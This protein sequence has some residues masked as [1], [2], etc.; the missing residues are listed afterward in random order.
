MNGALPKGRFLSY[1][2]RRELA[3]DP[4]PRSRPVPRRQLPVSGRLRVLHRRYPH[5]GALPCPTTGRIPRS[6]PRGA[7]RRRPHPVVLALVLVTGSVWLLAAQVAVFALGAFA[8]PR[9]PRTPGSSACSSRPR[10][11]P[12]GAARGRRAAAL[13]PGRRLR[14]RRRRAR[15]LRR[16]ASPRSASP[17]PRSRWPPRSSTRPS[18]SAWAASCTWLD[19][20]PAPPFD[21]CRH[22]EGSHPHEPRRTS[23]SPPT[24]PRRTSTTP[25]GSSSSKSTRTPPPTTAATSRAP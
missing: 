19:P 6:T 12:P 3:A 10:L 18:A 17:P 4:T 2:R 1:P 11:G 16:S 25:K 5:S 13:R 8:G 7:V 23:W 14:L 15:R 21:H 20:P 9:S 22:T 24:G